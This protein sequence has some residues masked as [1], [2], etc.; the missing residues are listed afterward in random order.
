MKLYEGVF[1]FPPEGTPENRKNQSKNLEDLFSR[2]QGEILHREEWGR[3]PL[4]YPV[5]KFK[6]GHFFTIDFRMNPHKTAEFQKA[7]QL[8]EDLIKFMIVIKSHRL[9]KKP[10]PKTHE[11]S[12][13]HSSTQLPAPSATP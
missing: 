2:F 5:R 4:G 8:Q 3:R 1:I 9:E 13:A 6:E 10:A 7:L 11:T 12:K